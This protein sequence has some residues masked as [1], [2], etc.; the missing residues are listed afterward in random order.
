MEDSGHVMNREPR[1]PGDGLDVGMRGREGKDDSA[2]G[3]VH[4][5]E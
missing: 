1:S 5:G 4:L 3:P 2:L